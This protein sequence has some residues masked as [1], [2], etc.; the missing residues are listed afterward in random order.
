MRVNHALDSKTDKR[1][2]DKQINPV[3]KGKTCPGLKGR[4]KGR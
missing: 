4:R 2:G 3:N 1:V